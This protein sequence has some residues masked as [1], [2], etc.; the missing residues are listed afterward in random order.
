MVVLGVKDVTVVGTVAASLAAVAA[1]MAVAAA[2]LVV[3]TVMAT[4]A[5]EAG[6]WEC[7]AVGKEL[8]V[9]VGV[10]LRANQKRLALVRLQADRR[11]RS[12]HLGWRLG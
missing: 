6:E 12:A 9:A 4:V 11:R 1:A 2:L 10:H 3:A 7:K 5:W 8:A